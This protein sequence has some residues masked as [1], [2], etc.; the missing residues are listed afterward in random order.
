MTSPCQPNGDLS[1]AESHDLMTRLE[2]CQKKRINCDTI[3]SLLSSNKS[4][5]NLTELIVQVHQSINTEISIPAKRSA[6]H[7]PLDDTLMVVAD[8]FPA[9]V[10]CPEIY[11]WKLGNE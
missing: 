5:P 6:H 3:A 8:E 4:K 10:V 9:T 1:V 2:I 11:C 7:V